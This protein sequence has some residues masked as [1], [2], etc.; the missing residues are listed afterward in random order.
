MDL[1]AWL[2]PL[3]DAA[4]QRTLD[5]WAI[6]Q[7]RIPAETLMERAGSA[8]ARVCADLV[9]D[10]PIVI[11]CGRG[12]NGGDGH[13]AGRVLRQLRREVT[14]VDVA[15]GAPELAAA[16]ERAAGV[17]DALL[18]TGFS[19]APREPISGAIA[20]INAGSPCS[21]P[22]TGDR[23]RRTRAASTA[24]PGRS[25]ERPFMPMRP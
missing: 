3:P 5:A 10:G 21:A 6:E 14:V 13:V 18:G 12:N 19:G 8:L 15:D 4:Q 9:P 1:P 2:T 17:V 20:A 11:V 7:H 25:A 24:P 16:L 23:L 22:A